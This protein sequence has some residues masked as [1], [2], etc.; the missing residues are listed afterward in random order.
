MNDGLEF[1]GFCYTRAWN[2]SHLWEV[3]VAGKENSIFAFQSSAT[4]DRI[5][6]FLAFAGPR[7]AL[8]LATPL[9]A[10]VLAAALGRVLAPIKGNVR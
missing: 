8:L 1:N 7:I 9:P 2:R 6:V 5:S 3:T 10:S 4:P